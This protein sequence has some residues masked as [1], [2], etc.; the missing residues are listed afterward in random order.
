MMFNI[1]ISDTR[2]FNENNHNLRLCF[3]FNS[4][5]LSARVGFRFDSEPLTVRPAGFSRVEEMLRSRFATTAAAPVR[6]AKRRICCSIDPDLSWEKRSC[7]DSGRIGDRNSD[8][9]GALSSLSAAVSSA[10]QIPIISGSRMTTAK[11]NKRSCESDSADA[12]S[13]I[14]FSAVARVSRA[15]KRARGKIAKI[16][17]IGRAQRDEKCFRILTDSGSG[18]AR[19]RHLSSIFHLRL[20]VR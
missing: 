2:S 10:A 1:R 8:S 3:F 11:C 20:S 15:E 16:N 12:S 4:F 5:A 13:V 9:L 7:D 6:A 18:S 19:L 14:D 17:N